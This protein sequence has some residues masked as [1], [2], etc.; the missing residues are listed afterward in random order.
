[1]KAP[2]EHQLTS[3]VKLLQKAVLVQG[4]KALILKRSADS[5]SRAEKWDLPGG[6]TEWPDGSEDI[7]NP[8]LQDVVREI[9]EE[10]GIELSTSAVSDCL[11]VGSYFEPGKEIYTIILGWGITL[12]L[13]VLQHDIVLSDEH[14]ASTWISLSEFD[15]YDFGFAGEQ[16]GFI[17]LMIEKALKR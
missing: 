16:N 12:P 10:T 17:R 4:E 7:R 8:H 3:E 15:Q 5:G 14:T 6:N 2:H 9:F 1:M 11:Y 13:D